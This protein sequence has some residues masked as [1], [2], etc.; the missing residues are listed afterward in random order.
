MNYCKL[1]AYLDFYLFMTRL[2]YFKHI[3]IKTRYQ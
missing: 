3:T 2:L 1:F